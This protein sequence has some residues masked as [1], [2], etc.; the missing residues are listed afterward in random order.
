MGLFDFLKKKPELKKEEGLIKKKKVAAPKA[1]P[2]VKKEKPI[3]PEI[4]KPEKKQEVKPVKAKKVVKSEVA[5]KVL[6][7]PHITEKATALTKDNEYVFRVF[8]RS[9]KIEVKQAVKDVYG[10]DVEKVRMI[11][12]PAKKRRLGKTQGWRKGYKKAIVKVKKGQEIEV[13][14]R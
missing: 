6:E 3:K 10:V 12:V 8:S 2:V 1:K 9:N 14:P 13:L 5:W 4:K 11:N 7:R